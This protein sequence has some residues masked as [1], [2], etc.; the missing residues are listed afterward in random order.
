VIVHPLD[1]HTEGLLD[2]P[3]PPPV[4]LVSHVN[5][6]EDVDDEHV[7]NI[8]PLLLDALQELVVSLV[9]PVVADPEVYV[10]VLAVGVLVA[11]KVLDP[12]APKLAQ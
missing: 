8:F 5:V 2:V 4:T 3:P 1:A 12:N 9:G 11:T 6:L 7:M 10:S